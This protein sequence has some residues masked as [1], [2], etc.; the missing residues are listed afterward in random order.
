MSIK[1][2]IAD[3]SSVIQTLTKKILISLNYDVTGV[4]NGNK[5]LQLVES[6]DYDVILMDINL[7]SIDGIS[8]TKK[9]RALSDKK[10]A[11]VP[12]IAISG[13]YKNYSQEDFLAIGI[14]DLLIK[15]LNY[16][17]LVEAVKK[18]TS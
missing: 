13:N 7:P 14:E 2:L 6:N 9:I 1:I 18:H 12:V 5:V 17:D 11:N 4:K 10:K 15:P 8:L 3:D 16:D